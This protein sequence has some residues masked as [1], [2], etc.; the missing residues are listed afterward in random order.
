VNRG[1]RKGAKRLY[2]P[3]DNPG[4]IS[5]IT[6][7]EKVLRAPM[8]LKNVDQ[9]TSRAGRWDQREELPMRKDHDSGGMRRGRLLGKWLDVE[10]RVSVGMLITSSGPVFLYSYRTT[11]KGVKIIGGRPLL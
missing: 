8:D 1:G 2:T 9:L 6:E 7:Q 4:N 11:K 10:W 3:E 5:C